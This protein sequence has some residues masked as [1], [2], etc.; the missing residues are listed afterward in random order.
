MRKLLCGLR[1]L[2]FAWY[3]ARVDTANFAD[4]G[5]VPKTLLAERHQGMAALASAILALPIAAHRGLA[6]F[7]AL[8]ALLRIRGRRSSVVLFV[9]VVVAVVV[10]V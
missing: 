6:L 8:L 3:S 5:V 2:T 9:H 10:C 7:V 1:E 4:C